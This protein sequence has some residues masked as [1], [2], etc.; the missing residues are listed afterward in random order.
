MPIEHP[1]PTEA[2]VKELY[3]TAFGCA[4][5]KCKAPL[6]RMNSDGTRTLNSRVAHICARR[7]NGPR[8]DPEMSDDENRAAENLILLCIP[9]S[10]EVDDPHRVH[11]FPVE[12]LQSWKA[13]Q[14]AEYD[15]TS[16]GWQ[17]TDAEADEVIR[18]SYTAEVIIQGDTLNLGGQGGQAP[19][20]GGAGG[21]AI[22]RGAV[23]G[24][25]GPGGPMIFNMSGQP[26]AAPGAGGGGG[27]TIDPESELLWR[28]PGR[29]P[30]VGQ[31][32]Y[33]GEDSQ[34]GGDTTIS[35]AEGNVLLRAKGGRPALAGSGVRSTSD[36]FSV[37]ALILANAVECTGHYVSLLNGGFSHYNVLNLNDQLRFAGLVTIEGGGIPQ[38]E[39][40]FTIQILA[41]NSTAAYTS[42]P[43]F[44]IIK[45]G[46]INRIILHFWTLVAVSEF[47]MWTIAF[48]HNG[49]E[50]AR[51]PVAVQQG[52]PGRTTA[53]SE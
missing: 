2:T 8:W 18:E 5:P 53:L 48:L 9:H 49:K 6:Y 44:Q 34:G 43:V 37:S 24:K 16:T 52:I 33:I 25:G 26:G 21:T 10:Y 13:Q 4:N 35:D 46:D 50:L 45:A 31:A 30:T 17:L 7:E 27:A 23:A 36:K 22:G 20:A 15:R 29:T 40:A 1:A 14:L 39:Y 3:A 19:S 28:G 42:T 11:L 47:G 51:L 41:P 32:E 38:G 12:L